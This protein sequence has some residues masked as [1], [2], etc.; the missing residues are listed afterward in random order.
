MYKFAKIVGDEAKVQ[1]ASALMRHVHSPALF[2]V[3][4]LGETP[5]RRVKSAESMV[6][7]RKVV[8]G[9]SV[10]PITTKKQKFDIRRGKILYYPC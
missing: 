3:S 8:F 7:G 5:H 2:G 9:I 10:T 1:T 4:P 6:V